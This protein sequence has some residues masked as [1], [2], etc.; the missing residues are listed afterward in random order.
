L[1]VTSGPCDDN[2][3]T[4]ADG[5]VIASTSRNNGSGATREQQSGGWIK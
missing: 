4:I 1:R 5:I 2:S 3:G